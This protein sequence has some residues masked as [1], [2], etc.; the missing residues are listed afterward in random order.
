MIVEVKTVI[1]RRIVG[2]CNGKPQYIAEL[3][4]PHKGGAIA[5]LKR[6]G[7]KD[8]EIDIPNTPGTGAKHGWAFE[9]KILEFNTDSNGEEW[10]NYSIRITEHIRNSSDG[11]TKVTKEYGILW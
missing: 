2:W 8:D 4:F 9:E 6:L 10:S 5:G 7:F 1:A 11:V 3:I